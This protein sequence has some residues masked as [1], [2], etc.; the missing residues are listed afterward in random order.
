MKKANGIVL[1]KPGKPDYRTP[2]SFRI[3][4]LLETVSKILERLSALCLASAARSLGLLHPN[5]CGSLAGRGCFDAV[6]TLTYEVRLL[7]AASFKVSTLFLDV[8]G[9]FDNVCANKLANT[10]TK[11]AGAAYLVAWIKCFLSKRQCRLICQGAPKA[12]CPVA[13][14]T[15]QGSPISPLLFVLYIAS[16]HSTIPQGLVISYFDDLTITVGSDSV[17]S[18]IRVLQYFFGL[19]QNRGA[20][21]GV[22]FSVPKTE[23]IPWR[24]PKDCSDV[25]FAPIVINNM[26]S[27]PS[28]AVSGLPTGSPRLFTPRYIS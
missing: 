22:A 13:V 26:L 18:N 25:S 16:L 1:H 12:F 4:V 11:G 28:E 14:G 27:P 2:G 9:G 24:T 8:K 6:A 20:D 3:I 7:Q 19:I 15:P 10:L 21:L 5:Q 23:L 17:G